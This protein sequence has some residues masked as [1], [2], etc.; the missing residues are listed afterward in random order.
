MG[1]RVDMRQWEA[2]NSKL[3]RLQDPDAFLKKACKEMAGRYLAVVI[4][5]TPVG[6]SVTGEDGNTISV[7]GTLRRGWTA[8]TQAEA[9]SGTGGQSP[10]AYA[11]GLTPTV[12]GDEY[13]V[14]VINPVEYASYVE[15]GHR[16]TPGRFVPA[17]GKRLKKSWVEGKFFV[18]TSE[19]ALDGSASTVLDSL[20]DR[21][22]RQGL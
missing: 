18:R 13:S 11:A 1:I 3:Q 15:Y 6:D 19:Q 5:A 4:P 22:L 2:F 14:D 8:R 21:Y 7:G 12:S 9:E 10:A 17:I 16:Q 20:V